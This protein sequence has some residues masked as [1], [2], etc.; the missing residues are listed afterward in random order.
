MDVSAE[1]AIFIFREHGELIGEKKNVNDV[2]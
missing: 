2:V 1:C